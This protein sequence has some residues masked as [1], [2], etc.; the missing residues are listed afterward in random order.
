[1][2]RLTHVPYTLAGHYRLSLWQRLGRWLRCCAMR[3]LP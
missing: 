3:Y 2:K 1:M